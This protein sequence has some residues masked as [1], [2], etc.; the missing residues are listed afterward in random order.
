MKLVKNDVK[1]VN[2]L[3]ILNFTKINGIMLMKVF[4]L[5]YVDK[6]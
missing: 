4:A 1:C 3:Y 6:R 2:N 5:Q